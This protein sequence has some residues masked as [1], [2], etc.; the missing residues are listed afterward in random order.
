[1][2]MCVQLQNNTNDFNHGQQKTSR[3]IKS[4]TQKQFYVR[5]PA[6]KP[7][8]P[9][10][11]ACPNLSTRFVP[12]NTALLICST[13]SYAY[14]ESF[15]RKMLPKLSSDWCKSV[16]E[17]RTT[18][19]FK[20]MT[21]KL[22]ED[23]SFAIKLH[24]CR[25]CSGIHNVCMQ[26]QTIGVRCCEQTYIFVVQ[27]LTI[28]RRACKFLRNAHALEEIQFTKTNWNHSNIRF[29]KNRLLTKYSMKRK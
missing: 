4:K 2:L 11:D 7:A 8:K 23:I 16:S 27:M 14:F 19:R 29:W 10:S 21:L 3:W 5:A 24:S 9:V 17:T 13:W 18:C 20:N 1:M 6:A 26:V 12:K 25:P 15:A 28:I 22:Y